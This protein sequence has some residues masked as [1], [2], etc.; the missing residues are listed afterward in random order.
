MSINVSDK[1]IVSIFR[2]G[3]GGRGYS[4]PLVHI[5]E[6]TW[7]HNSEDRNLDTHC[8]KILKSHKYIFI[9]VY[10]SRKYVSSIIKKLRGFG[11]LAN[12]ADRATAAS[13][14]SS[15]NFCG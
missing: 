11:P 4:E 2:V 8:R 15:S 5:Y 14:R 3:D 1:P 10:E 9:Y 7:R 12:Y 6:T 13:W